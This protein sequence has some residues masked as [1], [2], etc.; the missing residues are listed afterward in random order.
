MYFNQIGLFRRK[1]V[2]RNT[3]LLNYISQIS[4]S[5]MLNPV[6]HHWCCFLNTIWFSV[7]SV[8]MDYNG[9][10]WCLWKCAIHVVQIRIMLSDTRNAVAVF[11]QLRSHVWVSL[12]L[13]HW[14]SI[15]CMLVTWSRSTSRSHWSTNTLQCILQLHNKVI[16][17]KNRSVNVPGSDILSVY[18]MQFFKSVYLFLRYDEPLV[19]LVYNIKPLFIAIIG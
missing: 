11:K 12:M 17:V 3:I 18:L 4:Y 14:N 10:M 9:K 19:H 13:M 16:T 5:L 1:A 2:I 15:E 6:Y 7:A 8:T